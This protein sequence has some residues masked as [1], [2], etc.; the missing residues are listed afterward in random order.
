[1]RVASAT[2]V[3]W[4]ANRVIASGRASAKSPSAAGTS[5]TA[6]MRSPRDRSLRTRSSRSS[7]A[8]ELIRGSSAVISE[9]ATIAC[10][11]WKSW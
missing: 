5:T 11:S 4:W 10:G 8:C 9:T 1:M 7:A 6:D 3:A 2:V